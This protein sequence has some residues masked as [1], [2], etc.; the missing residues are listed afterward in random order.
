MPQ[1][2]TLVDQYFF[3]LLK[4]TR[5][6]QHQRS[7]FC[8][9]ELVSSAWKSCCSSLEGGSLP[10]VD[11]WVD[12]S[13][14][15]QGLRQHPGAIKNFTHLLSNL[16]TDLPEK[17]TSKCKGNSLHSLLLAGG[18]SSC[19]LRMVPGGLLPSV[20]GQDPFW[21]SKYLVYGN[22]IFF[23]G[24]LYEQLLQESPQILFKKEYSLLSLV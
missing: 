9:S 1:K 21:E 13:I 15:H 2:N 11:L 16:L 4:G 6:S 19:W 8:L 24:R 18:I 22:D 12:S 23:P 5:C 3:S 7:W 10:G 17:M 20:L 14:F